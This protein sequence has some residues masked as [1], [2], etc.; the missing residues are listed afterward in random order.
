MNNL[1]KKI[2]LILG[3]FLFNIGAVSLFGSTAL[4]FPLLGITLMTLM[5]SKQTAF[6][7]ALVTG[8]IMEIYSPF[9]TLAYFLAILVVFAILRVFITKY[10]S[11][12]TI[13]GAMA[14][15]ALGVLCF[16]IILKI[17]AEI[18][19]FISAGGW[20]PVLNQN[21]LWF[22][23]TRLLYNTLAVCLIFSILRQFSTQVRGVAIHNIGKF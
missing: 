10:M 23:L 12:R 14:S 13:F 19:A 16:E 11:N 20:L 2:L 18:S 8:I 6:I 9:P 1:Y 3:A 7:W 17:L 15:S 22:I 5:T 21:Y 4:S